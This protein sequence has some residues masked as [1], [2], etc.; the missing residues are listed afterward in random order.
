M[1]PQLVIIALYLCIANVFWVGKG[2]SRLLLCGKGSSRL[3]SQDGFP[4]EGCPDIYEPVCCDKRDF[5]N[6]CVAALEGY[7]Q[8]YSGT[9]GPTPRP[10]ERPSMNPT[11]PTRAPM[12][13]TIYPTELSASGC[14][15]GHCP[16]NTEYGPVCCCIIAPGPDPRCAPGD[17]KWAGNNECQA[18]CSL[19][20]ANFICRAMTDIEKEWGEC[21]ITD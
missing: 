13:P 14:G 7:N 3:L 16:P 5:S 15:S 12:I 18:Y 4:D 9:C 1:S 17:Y 2:A 8:C 11:V 20:D 19:K 21:L 10:T 6:D